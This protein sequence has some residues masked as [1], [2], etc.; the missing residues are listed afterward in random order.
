[1][2]TAHEMYDQAIQLKQEGDL[3]AA[4]AK[5]NEVTALDAKHVDAHSALA[6]FHQ[7]LGQFEAAVEHAK[8]VCEL[9]P[10]DPFSFTQLSVICVKCG[11][12]QE[13][14]DARAL[15]HEA[16]ARANS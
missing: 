3:E 7:K 2:P 8:K 1:M 15:A 10:N 16:Q 12:I 13:A 6:V 11:M 5:L 4:I 9:K 14:E